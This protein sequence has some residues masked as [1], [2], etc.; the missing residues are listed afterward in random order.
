MDMYVAKTRFQPFA[1]FWRGEG[2]N[3]N[4]Y[5]AGSLELRFQKDMRGSAWFLTRSLEGQDEI[6]SEDSLFSFARDVLMEFAPAGKINHVELIKKSMFSAGLK[7][8]RVWRG[9][10]GASEEVCFLPFPKNDFDD[11]KYMIRA[12]RNASEL[13]GEFTN[14][15]RYL[16]PH[17]D[18]YESYSNKLREL[19]MLACTEIEANFIGVLRSNGLRSMGTNYN[20]GDFIRLIDVLHL[21][22]WGA[23]LKLR[24][25]C[26]NVYP[27]R[28]WDAVKPTRSLIWYDAYNKVK[29]DSF[30]NLSKANFHNVYRAMSALYVLLLAQWGLNVFDELGLRVPFYAVSRPDF[31]IVEIPVAIA[32]DSE[33]QYAPL[34]V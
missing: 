3:V 6:E 21:R 14:S 24:S 33:P 2:A 26:G 31:D 34:S 23:S 28:E 22:S 8:R 12:A 13:F 25:G 4:F 30:E 20:T 29:H 9:V 7:Y 27:F 1:A 11:Y 5:I 17:T 15:F 32:T 18:N 19:L 16:E 10:F